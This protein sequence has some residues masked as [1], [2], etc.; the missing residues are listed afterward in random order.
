MTPTPPAAPAER[1]KATIYG[2][3]GIVTA[4]LCCPPLGILFGWLSISEAR[5][6]GKDEVIGT[7]AFWAG[8]A[9]TAL[10]VLGG[11]FSICLGGGLGMWS[12]HY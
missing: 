12:R 1:D 3:I 11:I 8:I 5:K 2:V 6:V 10:G 4:F 9:M 7:V